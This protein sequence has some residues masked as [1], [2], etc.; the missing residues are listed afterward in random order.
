VALTDEFKDA[1]SCWASG[2]AVVAVNDGGLVY[3]I[4]VS[5]FTSVSADPPL[6][7]VCLNNDNRMPSMIE[8]AGRFA[9]SLLGSDQEDASVYFASPGREPTRG[10][11]GY[12]G[13]WSVLR[14][15]IVKGAI[16]H[17]VC[18]LHDR[19]QAGTHA[20]VI[21]Q[22]VHADSK[23]DAHP[24]LYFQRGYRRVDPASL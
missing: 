21:G 19:V 11:V 12:E 8:R 22:V 15:P 7:L 17:L 2:V 18:E 1:L 14:Q 3:G 23:P 4:T 20:V 16:A 5:S 13:E 6:I 24:L 9:V 10:F